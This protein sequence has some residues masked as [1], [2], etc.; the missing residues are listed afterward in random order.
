MEDDEELI[1]KV[2]DK[3][4]DP[5]LTKFFNENSLLIKNHKTQTYF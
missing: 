4:N 5:Q 2:M 1:K 3:D